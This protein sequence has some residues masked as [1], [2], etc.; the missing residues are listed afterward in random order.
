MH[1]IITKV[2][3]L[4]GMKFNSY[5]A[6]GEVV[7]FDVKTI[8]DRYPVFHALEN[9]ELFKMIQI[10]GGGYGVCWNDDLDLSS[11]GIF[12]HGKIIAKLDPQINIIVGQAIQEAREE[13]GISQRELSRTSGV[14]QAEISKIEQGKGNPTISTLQKLAKSLG[15]SISSF[16][17]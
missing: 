16:L 14:M 5:F 8:M 4:D 10:D 3:P 6:T 13:K 11:D 7:T 12:N 15:R 2:E 17:L 1:R 9:E